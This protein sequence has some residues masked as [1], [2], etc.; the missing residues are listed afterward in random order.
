MIGPVFFVL[1]QTSIKRGI[2]SALAFD[3]GVLI[4]DLVYVLIAYLFYSEVSALLSGEKQDVMKIIGGALFLIYGVVTFFK[5]TKEPEIDDDGNLIQTS[6]DYV[7]LGLKG[8]LLNFANPM[9]IFYWIS[10]ISFGARTDCDGYSQGAI[11]FYYLLTIIITFFSID[12]LKILGAK[13][14]RPLVTDAILTALNH[15]IGI[16]FAGFGIFLIIKGIL[17]IM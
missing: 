12:V 5:K 8:F 9:V 10:V 6:S 13:K 15:F 16:T 11:I 2:R 14:L 4:S 7:V 3:L 17:G 1:L